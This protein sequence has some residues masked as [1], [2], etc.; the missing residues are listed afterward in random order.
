MSGQTASDLSRWALLSIAAALVTMGL[1]FAAWAVTGSVGLLSDA[2]ESSVNLVA[3]IAAFIALKVAARPAD[4]GH[5]FGHTKAEYFSA[6]TEGV[7]II[8]AAAVIIGTAVDRLLHPRELESLGI[9]LGIAVVA[10]AVNGAVALALL[11]VGRRE[12]SMTLTADGHHLL[13]DVWTTAGVVIGVAVVA[14][15]GWNV[16]DPIIAI[17]VAIN[18]VVV[19]ARLIRASGAGL[20][21]AALGDE[22]RAAID[23]V[24]DRHRTGPAGATGNITGASGATGECIGAS[25][26]TGNTIGV[27]GATGDL[28]EFH[29]VRTREAGRYRFAQLHMLVPGSWT[30]Q[31]GHDLAEQVEEE[32]REAVDDLAVVIHLEPIEDERSYESWRR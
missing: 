27:S 32:L 1:K 18:I 16:L 2:A 14:L 6:V 24:L 19:G 9:G 8:V 26:A 10:A 23:A 20:M 12:R 11:R 25:E 3:A 22:Q 4:D 7:M 21:D 17:L 31:R 13:T 30:V 15:T 29:D 5:N 28:I